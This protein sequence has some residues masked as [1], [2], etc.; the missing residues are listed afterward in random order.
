MLFMHLNRPHYQLGS[1][2]DVALEKSTATQ[3]AARRGHDCLSG[4]QGYLP[5]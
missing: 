1:N 3:G 4:C 2:E 5:T